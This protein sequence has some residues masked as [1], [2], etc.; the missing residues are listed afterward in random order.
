MV[1]TKINISELKSEGNDIIKNLTEF[2]KEKVKTETEATLD[3]IVLKGEGKSISKK[4][5]RVLIKRF[6][7]QNELK[8]YYRV[9]SDKENALMIKE[10]K[11]GEEQE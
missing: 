3:A 5:L 1:E 10:R 2:L 8:D 11:I 7:H 4:H 9:I 6:L